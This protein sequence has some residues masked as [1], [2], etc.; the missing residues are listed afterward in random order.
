MAE[1]LLQDSEQPKRPYSIDLSL[2]LERQLDN[3][4]LPPTPAP[5]ALTARPASLDQTVLASIIHQ[6]QNSLTEV[7][8]ERDDL[9]EKLAKANG[10]KG[11]M[12]ETLQQFSY[13]CEKMEEELEEAK[14][15]MRDDEH[16]ISM[17]RTKVEESR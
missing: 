10:D 5:T 16:A 1:P 12:E 9:W 14:A 8:K 17:L 13:K 2:E 6:L 15:K 3:E 7:T 4:S 11:G